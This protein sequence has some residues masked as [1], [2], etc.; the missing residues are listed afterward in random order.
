MDLLYI[1]IYLLFQSYLNIYQIKLYLYYSLEKMA[2]TKIIFDTDMGTDDAWALATLLSL[3]ERCNLD[4]KAITIVPGNTT[5]DHACQNALLVLKSLKREDIKVYAGA[6][7]SLIRKVG[8]KNDYHGEDGFQEIFSPTQK[9]SLDLLQKEHAVDI[10]RKLI[11]DVKYF[12]NFNP[13]RFNFCLLEPKRD[14]NF[15]NWTIDESCTA[16]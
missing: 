5:R 14:C 16:L 1:H 3:E 2:K 11:E 12:L 4:V 8:F 10:M 13:S 9:P 7:D 6:Q 15:C